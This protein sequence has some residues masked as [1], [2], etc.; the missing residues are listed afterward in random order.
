MRLSRLWESPVVTARDRK[1]LLG[2]LVEEVMLWRDGTAKVIR[3]LVRWHGGA[4]DEFEL[5]S[6]QA[7]AVVRDDIDTVALVRRLAAH[8]PDARTAIIL[9]RQGRRTAKG[10]AFTAYLVRQLRV[11]NDIP[12]W[13]A[14]RR[15]PNAPLLSVVEAARELQTTDGTLYRWIRA[16]IVPAEQPA[17]GAPYRIRMTPELRSQFCDEPPAGFVSLH[18]AMKRL[19]V[20][21]QVIWQRIRS[22][23]L[24]ARH[25]RRGSVKGLYVQL[26]DD[27]LPLF[28]TAE[29]GDG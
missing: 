1:R 3:I 21:R 14:D 12:A 23:A 28:E 15:D 16:G 18:R 27:R 8:Y 20:S 4:T 10:L 13:R 5:P 24:E 19:G 17:S 25:I 7:P 22:G 9:N 6:H 11:R 26:G 2:C 29:A